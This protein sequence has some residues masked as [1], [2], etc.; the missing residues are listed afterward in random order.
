MRKKGFLTIGYGNIKIWEF[1]RIIKEY[2]VNCIIDVRSRPYNKYRMEYNKD[3][4]RDRL[5]EENIVYFWLGNKLGSRHDKIGLCDE[6][7][8]VDYEKVAGSEMFKEGIEKLEE[9]VNKYNVC[10]MCSEKD[11]MNC[12]R[13]LLISRALKEYNIFHIIPGSRAISNKKLEERLMNKYGDLKQISLFDDQALDTLE[14]IA[15]SKQGL[16]TAYVSNIVKELI[17]QGITEDI[18]EKTRMY[19]IGTEGKTSQRFFELLVDYNIKKV[20]DIRRDIKTGVPF[21]IYPDIEYYLGLHG[22]A[23]YRCKELVPTKEMM[24][25]NKKS[26]T[27]NAIGKYADYITRNGGINKLLSDDLNGTCFLGSYDDYKMCHRSVILSQLKKKKENI[28]TRHLR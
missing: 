21:C 5:N 11:P 18:P 9:Y 6:Q 16:K 27:A 20:V 23:Y 7:G 10:I 19:C 28:V 24:E 13:F 1:I 22:I 26:L 8:R 2:R 17:A 3:Y 25:Y 14:N 15:Y 12:H 4:L